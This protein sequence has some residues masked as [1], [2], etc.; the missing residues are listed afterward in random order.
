MLR[1]SRF[2]CAGVNVQPI[3]EGFE[4]A[5]VYVRAVLPERVRDR[6]NGDAPKQKT[7]DQNE[8][9]PFIYRA[10]YYPAVCWC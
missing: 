10:A 7:D 6:P 8:R 4:V 2:G 5:L 1:T 3:P 9:Q